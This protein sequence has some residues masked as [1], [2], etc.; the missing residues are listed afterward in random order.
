MDI[1]IT[2]TPR[3]TMVISATPSDFR[4]LADKLETA[5]KN[6][7]GIKEFI[8]LEIG[9]GFN[10]LYRIEKPKVDA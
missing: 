7:I 8:I 10:V 5:A 3:A 2:G 4:Q 1:K 6:A 9:D